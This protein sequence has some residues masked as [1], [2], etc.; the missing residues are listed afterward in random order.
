MTLMSRRGQTTA[1]YKDA[2][3][4]LQKRTLALKSN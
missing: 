2:Y 1:A 4:L 3:R